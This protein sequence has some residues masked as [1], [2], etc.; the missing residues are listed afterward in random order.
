MNINKAHEACD[1]GQILSG[2][3]HFYH[4]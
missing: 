4:T 1:T 3:S 2:E